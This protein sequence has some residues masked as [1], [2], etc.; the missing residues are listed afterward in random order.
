MGVLAESVYIFTDSIVLAESI[1]VRYFGDDHLATTCPPR[2]PLARTFSLLATTFVLPET[3]FLV[4]EKEKET[5]AEGGSRGGGRRATLGL[6]FSRE[7]REIRKGMI[8][9]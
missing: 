9:Y 7:E 8:P 2:K 5:T 1:F 4:V 6:G 3:F